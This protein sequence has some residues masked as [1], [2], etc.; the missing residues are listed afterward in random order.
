MANKHVQNVCE[1]SGKPL[2]FEKPESDDA[3]GA[4]ADGRGVLKAYCFVCTNTPTFNKKTNV[5]RKHSKDKK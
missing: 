2:N 3:V 1:G 4:I 5:F